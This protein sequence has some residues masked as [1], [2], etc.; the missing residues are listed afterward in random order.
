MSETYVFDKGANLS[1]TFGAY[2]TLIEQ[3]IE[4]ATPN[5]Y[6][7]MIIR[8]NTVPA[9]VG[10]PT[11]Y[12]TNWYNFQ[13]RSLWTK[14]NGETYFYNGVTWEYIRCRPAS[15]A[16]DNSMIANATIQIGKFSS[17]GGTVSQLIR[18][19]AA[20]GFEYVDAINAISVN[21]FPVD[22]LVAPATGT[23][24]LRSVTGVKA[25]AEFNST[26]VVGAIDNN[27]IA[28]NKLARGS[29]LQVPMV[30]SDGNSIVWSSVIAGITDGALSIGKIATSVGDAGKFLK[31]G[32]DGKLVAADSGVVGTSASVA[33]N[34]KL[35][36]LTSAGA[37]KNIPTRAYDSGLIA[38]NGSHKY[39]Q[40]HNFGVRPRFTE[41]FLEC[42][43][44]EHGYTAGDC[45]PIE[46]FWTE[47]AGD[48]RPHFTFTVNATIW[49]ITVRSGFTAVTGCY[50]H[51]RANGNDVTISPSNWRLRVILTNI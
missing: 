50:I 15:L 33:D 30:A 11:G 43:N 13:Q 40:S 46:A 38:F 39:E 45:V 1:P 16:L 48:Q 31:Y 12:P 29:A 23:H 21:T 26:L 37:V 20:G 32:T 41:V 9:T 7:G 18:V 47:S 27:S 42:V 51:N 22:R 2:A 10:Q 5:A 49:S 19:A 4:R 35:V 3:A 25:W 6:R 8:S 24:I 34:D 44:A 36:A 28:I 14:D 17:I